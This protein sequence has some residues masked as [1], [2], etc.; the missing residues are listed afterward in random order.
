MS[1]A[2]WRYDSTG[3]S[4]RVLSRLFAGAF[5]FDTLLPHTG[6]PGVE[7]RAFAVLSSLPSQHNA[8]GLTQSIIEQMKGLRCL[9]VRE[10]TG[11]HLVHP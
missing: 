3:G 7:R 5:I 8:K 1:S 4:G 11:H 9:H 2:R 10:P 6:G